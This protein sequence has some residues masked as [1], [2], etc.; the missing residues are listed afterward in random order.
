MRKIADIDNRLKEIH[1]EIKLLRQE[2]RMALLLQRP[3]GRIKKLR[4]KRG[5][6]D[7]R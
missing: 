7:A 4:R 3:V 6:T 2:R 1:A 5:A